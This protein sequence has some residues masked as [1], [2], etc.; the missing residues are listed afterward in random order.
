MASAGMVLPGCMPSSKTLTVLLS[1]SCAWPRRTQL[2]STDGSSTGDRGR[3]GEPACP[4]PPRPRSRDRAVGRGPPVALHRVRRLLRRRP[5][6]LR[7]RQPRPRDRALAEEPARS[8]PTR[9]PGRRRSAPPRR[10]QR[11]QADRRGCG[12]ADRRARRL[13]ALQA[14]P[15]PVHPA[16]VPPDG[17]AA[18]PSGKARGPGRRT[19]DACATARARRRRR[20]APRGDRSAAHRARAAA[21]L[22][23]PAR[24]HPPLRAA[25]ARPRGGT[26]DDPQRHPVAHGR[27][28]AASPHLVVA[29]GSSAGT[30]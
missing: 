7:A 1:T 25:D 13:R 9:R 11:R 8:A 26:Y 30:M 22:M 5:G 12:P 29:S 17:A 18:P 24:A 16:R 27:H 15:P 3:G 28:R 20:P 19:A 21:A 4:D 2:G 23:A 10:D 14:R 6:R